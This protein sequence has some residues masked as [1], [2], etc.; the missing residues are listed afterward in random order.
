MKSLFEPTRS[1]ESFHIA[2]FSHH[3]GFKVFSELKVGTKVELRHEPD[4]PY[5]PEAVAIYYGE[6]KIGY[7]PRE[8]NSEF[9]T[10]LYFGHEDLFEAFICMVNDDAHPERQLRVVVTISDKREQA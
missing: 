4:N 7:V 3:E 5:D 1:L 6:T 8:H 2:G 10:Y 9:F